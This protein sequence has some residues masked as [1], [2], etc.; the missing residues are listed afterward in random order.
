MTTQEEQH[1]SFERSLTTR[2]T[3]SLTLTAKKRRRSM[4]RRGFLTK[5]SQKI[6]MGGAID[7]ENSPETE[8]VDVWSGRATSLELRGKLTRSS[9]S[10]TLNASRVR[11]SDSLRKKKKVKRLSSTATGKSRDEKEKQ[12]GIVRNG[13]VNDIMNDVLTCTNEDVTLYFLATHESFM[14]SIQLMKK[15]R[16]IIALK[17]EKMKL[18]ALLLLQYW[19]AS[20][21]WNP[22]DEKMECLLTKILEEDLSQNESDMMRKTCREILELKNRK[23]VSSEEEDVYIVDQIALTHGSELRLEEISMFE[24]ASHLS[25]MEYDI[26]INVSHEEYLSTVWSKKYPASNRKDDLIHFF[27]QTSNWVMTEILKRANLLS[28]AKII[29]LFID[30]ASE[31]KQLQNYNSLFAIV[32]AFDSPPIHKLKKTFKAISRDRRSL[33]SD[34]KLFISP[35]N[36]YS[37]YRNELACCKGPR[38]PYIG[39][40][41]SDLLYIS[42]SPD[43]DEDVSGECINFEKNILIGRVIH[44]VFDAQKD[45]Y[46][47]NNIQSYFEFIKFSRSDLFE[48]D[49]LYDLSKFYTDKKAK[50]PVEV[51]DLDD[52]SE[53]DIYNYFEHVCSNNSIYM[54]FKEYLSKSF[55]STELI[56][57]R[58][59]KHFRKSLYR[60]SIHTEASSIIANHLTEGRFKLKTIQ[61]DDPVFEEVILDISEIEVQTRDYFDPL[62]EVLEDFLRREWI[63]FCQAHL[64]SRKSDEEEDISELAILDEVFNTPSIYLKFLDYLRD[65]FCH[66]YLEFWAETRNLTEEEVLPIAEKWLGYPNCEPNISF[67]DE[68]ISHIFDTISSKAY[69]SHV[70]DPLIGDCR[71]ILE[72]KWTSFKKAPR[73]TKKKRRSSLYKD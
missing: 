1:A 37:L 43:I 44:D 36:G 25:K 54:Q 66:E 72:S 19:I 11:N 23:F 17:K 53:E 51:I 8:E 45:I 33:L 59:L 13:T 24:L 46:T 61:L 41:L 49:L 21:C 27:N 10:K 26:F 12:F 69:D 6:D 29:S 4:K 7:E 56:L 40:I 34:L 30:L 65:E 32:S 3:T 18:Q 57:Y 22:D 50:I 39:L 64:R 71:E 47:C 28:R 42:E 38:I 52:I 67:S 60:S 68:L 9:S 48:E 63:K 55:E 62:I 2:K 70:Y 73:K 20:P 58:E 14:S 5:S 16:S 31:M 15:I 35:K